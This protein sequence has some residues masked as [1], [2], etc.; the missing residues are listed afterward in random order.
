MLSKNI[1]EIT[2][3]AILLGIYGAILILNKY[4]F[5]TFLSAL[6]YVVVADIMIIFMTKY[7]KS[8]R[9]YSLI[10]G[11]FVLNFLSGDIYIMVYGPRH[12]FRSGILLWS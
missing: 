11:A 10:F 5:A 3:G 1:R 4:V 2:E 12:R 9:I 6:C 7:P 8:K